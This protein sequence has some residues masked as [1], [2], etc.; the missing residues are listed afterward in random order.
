MKTHDGTLIPVVVKPD[1]TVKDLKEKIEDV[2]GVPV[3][4]QILS[5]KGKP[6]DDPKS[7]MEDNGIQDG[8]TLDL[9]P[10]TNSNT[11]KQNTTHNNNSKYNIIVLQ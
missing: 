4:D 5:R 6:L 10:S 9:N 7:T 3:H 2:G 1:D 8:D 11:T